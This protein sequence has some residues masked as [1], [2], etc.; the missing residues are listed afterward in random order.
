LLLRGFRPLARPFAFRAAAHPSAAFVV[1][2]FEGGWSDAPHEPGKSSASPRKN[3]A[4]KGRMK[5]PV[6]CSLMILAA[7]GSGC[8]QSD[9]SAD[10][11]EQI[12]YYDR[13]S[14]GKV[15]ME[16]HEIPG[17]SDTNWALEDNDYDGRYEKKI[18]WGVGVFKSTVDIPVATN[19][20]TKPYP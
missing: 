20:Q 18:V 12:S 11:A 5:H 15:D 13:N 2:G 6:L 14:D 16:M 17:G 9:R 8:G 4:A 10:F 7:L 3:Q 19:V 1:A